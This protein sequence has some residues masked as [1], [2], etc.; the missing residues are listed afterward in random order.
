M[1]WPRA[2]LALMI[3]TLLGVGIAPALCGLWLQGR[4]TNDLTQL[5]TWLQRQNLQHIRVELTDSQWGWFSSDYEIEL[6]WGSENLLLF[7]TMYHG[8]LPS[9]QR[10]EADWQPRLA[11]GET[12]LDFSRAEWPFVMPELHFSS[13]IDFAGNADME[14]RF[15]GYRN[16]HERGYLDIASSSGELHYYPAAKRLSGHLDVPDLRLGLESQHWNIAGMKTE[17]DFSRGDSVLPVGA[18]QLDIQQGRIQLGE[19]TYRFD[20]VEQSW[21]MSEFDRLSNIQWVLRAGYLSNDKVTLQSASWDSIL[22]GISEI[23]LTVLRPEQSPPNLP[24]LFAMQLQQIKSRAA[25]LLSGTE[26]EIAHFETQTDDG[27]AQGF[28]RMQVPALEAVNSMPPRALLKTMDVSAEVSVPQQALQSILANTAIQKKFELSEK[29]RY[30]KR[31]LPA[32][33]L[34]QL[35]ESAALQQLRIVVAQ[36]L[37]HQDSDRYWSSIQLKEGRLSFNGHPVHGF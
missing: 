19:T 5:N 17:F 22:R 16:E 34:N 20:D 24:E 14:W 4:I 27:Q 6:A 33:E 9:L 12:R 18:L 35:A 26:F 25:Q 11:L 30:L 36:G 2:L 23:S 13:V 32:E 7:H 1:N 21:Q 10:L 8:P 31:K 15:L 3:L 29:Y 37:L 28:M